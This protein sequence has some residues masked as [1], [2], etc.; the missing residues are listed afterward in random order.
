M[1]PSSRR[2]PLV[3][4]VVP[5]SAFVHNPYNATL[6]EVV[7]Q[8]TNPKRGEEAFTGANPITG[9]NNWGTSQVDLAAAGVVAG[10]TIRLRWDFGQD[11]CNGNDGWYVDRVQVFTC[12]EDGPPPPPPNQEIAR[13]TLPTS[14]DIA[15]PAGRRLDDDRDGQP[16]RQGRSRTSTSVT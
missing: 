11:G 8:N 1:A 6:N 5:G 15:D 7:D 13:S 9:D 2:S 16:V 10:D 12:G 14:S 4:D 3:Y